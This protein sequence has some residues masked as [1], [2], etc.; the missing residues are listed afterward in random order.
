MCSHFFVRVMSR[1][2]VFSIRSSFMIRVAFTPNDRAFPE[3]NRDVTRVETNVL[4][5]SFEM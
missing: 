4:H 3:S 2:A 5:A 1:A